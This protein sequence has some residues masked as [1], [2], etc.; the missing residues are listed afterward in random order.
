MVWPPGWGLEKPA[1]TLAGVG[2]A[3]IPQVSATPIT[4]EFEDNQT[5]VCRP[6]VMKLPQTLQGLIG[7]DIL[8]QLGLVLT[9]DQ[10]LC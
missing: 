7:H 5:I 3:Q 1:A 10:H 2:G 9:T 4:L 6:Y 8:A